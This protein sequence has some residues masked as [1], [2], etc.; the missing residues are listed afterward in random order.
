M[1]NS[2]CRDK[3]EINRITKGQDIYYDSCTIDNDTLL[4]KIDNLE[5]SSTIIQD[6]I[7]IRG[8]TMEEKI[9]YNEKMIQKLFDI[10]NYSQ[11]PSILSH[12]AALWESI[13]RNLPNDAVHDLSILL[14]QKFV[15]FFPGGFVFKIFVRLCDYDPDFYQII[16]ESG[17]IYKI[18]TFLEPE[19]EFLLLSLELV[20]SMIC[21]N[22]IP[23]HLINQIMD[24]VL[25]S[26]EN[27]VVLCFEFIQLILHYNP[28]IAIRICSHESFWKM[29]EISKN[30]EDS[31]S[32]F[33]ELISI[34][35]LD[36][37]VFPLVMDSD[38]GQW[39]YE[40]IYSFNNRILSKA[41]KIIRKICKNALG[42][43]LIIQKSFFPLLLD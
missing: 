32:S 18:I 2:F 10:Q 9:I 6:L 22:Y 34:L 3:S 16:I 23:S 20:N 17:L 39:L 42:I 19:N 27:I 21:A 37:S 31:L 36:S 43:E 29:L 5:R 28:E 26:N 30:S 40:S 11:D 13:I 25:V 41:L 33:M 24:I 8:Y 38:F 4:E 15:S 1:L 7:E 14:Y 35:V 12:Y